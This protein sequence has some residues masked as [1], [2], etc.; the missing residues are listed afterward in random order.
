M[1]IRLDDQRV[2]TTMRTPGHDYELAVGFCLSEGLLAGAP[3]RAVRYCATGSAAETA[4]NV[5]TVSSGG[6]APVPEPRLQ[7]ATSSCGLCG[8][9]SIDALRQ[10]LGRSP[11]RHPG[12]RPRRPPPGRGDRPATAGAV[13]RDRIHPRRRGVRSRERRGGPVREDI[14]RHNAVDKVIGRMHLDGELPADGCSAVRLRPGQL[15][16]RAEGVGGRLRDARRRQRAECA[17]GAHGAGGRDG[18]RGVP[19]GTTANVLRA[20]PG[21]PLPAW[22]GEPQAACA[23]AR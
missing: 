5:V 4:F 21:S 3:V 23:A 11:S 17:G 7:A 10:R 20:R 18:P 6:L 19:P 12:G 9:A 14:G 15:R 8:A 16:D 2:T 1:E 22:L 13:R